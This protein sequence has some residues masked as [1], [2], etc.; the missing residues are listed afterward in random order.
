MCFNQSQ[1][2]MNYIKAYNI[3]VERGKQRQAANKVKNK[4]YHMHHIIPRCLG[5]SDSDDN[6]TMLTSKEHYICHRLLVQ[7]HKD[8]PDVTVKKQLFGAVQLLNPRLNSSIKYDIEGNEIIFALRV[9]YAIISRY[10]GAEQSKYT[11]K[12]CSSCGRK[13]LLKLNDS[14]TVC[15]VCQVSDDGSLYRYNEC[16]CGCG[17]STYSKH[18]RWIKGHLTECACGC[19]SVKKVTQNLT[20]ERLYIHGHNNTEQT[21]RQRT[22][23]SIKKHLDCLTSQEIEKRI[24]PMLSCDQVKKGSKISDTKSS[25]ILVI[26]PDGT[27]QTV[28]SNELREKYNTCISSV[29]YYISKHGGLQ[30]STGN[31]FIIIDRGINGRNV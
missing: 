16:L 31:K 17:Y 25:T 18:H 19:G 6:L 21:K 24:K 12:I 30:R 27:Q 26:H 13:T 1:N 29:R 8:I 5:G 2:H 11:H 23:A 14:G 15:R 10:G 20:N 28:K 22:S 4:G 7:I 3:L 9:E